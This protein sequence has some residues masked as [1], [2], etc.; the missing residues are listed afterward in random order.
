MTQGIRRPSTLV[1]LLLLAVVLALWLLFAWLT[2]AGRDEALDRATHGLTASANIFAEYAIAL[3][4]VGPGDERHFVPLDSVRDR[5]RLD[6]F[7]AAMPSWPGAHVHL[8]R[9]SDGAWLAGEPPDD[10]AMEALSGHPR[11][12]AGGRLVARA[13]AADAG[14]VATAD[15]TVAEVLEEWRQE[16]L[17][18]ASG[19]FVLTSSSGSGRCS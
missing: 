1:G 18:E 3:A 19:L 9:N 17:V 11:N 14:S 10:A 2:I 12:G 7:R 16:A 15:W 13:E 5:E 4:Q 8:L 6:A